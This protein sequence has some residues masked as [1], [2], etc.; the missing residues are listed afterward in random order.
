DKL[1]L[2]TDNFFEAIIKKKLWKEPSALVVYERFLGYLDAD[3]IKELLD[4]EFKHKLRLNP[5]SLLDNKKRTLDKT[6]KLE[7]IKYFLRTGELPKSYQSNLSN[8]LQVLK[9]FI[10]SDQSILRYLIPEFNQTENISKAVVKLSSKSVLF[11]SVLSLLKDKN[12]DMHVLLKPPLEKFKDVAYSDDFYVLDLILKR[13]INGPNTLNL[14][15]SINFFKEIKQYSKELSA[16][17]FENGTRLLDD[18]KISMR[19]VVAQALDF[20]HKKEDR[21]SE[22]EES[23]QL[24]NETLAVWS[25]SKSTDAEDAFDFIDSKIA[26]KDYKFI[27]TIF[28][29]NHIKNKLLDQ[30][31]KAELTKKNELLTILE[32]EKAKSFSLT[33][34]LQD[35]DKLNLST[36]NFFEAIIKKKLWKEPSALVVYERFLGYLDADNI[37]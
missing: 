22:D 27:R 24:H 36:D 32:A 30:F 11:K 29:N 23:Y 17:I 12:T 15:T 7:L 10:K 3:N 28:E 14:T 2:S 21:I 20:Y 19:S 6:D 33:S 18:G 34:I 8:Q 25:K 37:K 9:S 4:L 16:V 26:L 1:N 13:L 31:I 35:I 5:I